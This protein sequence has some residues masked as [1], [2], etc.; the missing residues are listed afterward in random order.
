MTSGKSVKPVPSATSRSSAP[1]GADA[2]STSPVPTV[3]S[4]T[5]SSCAACVAAAAAAAAASSASISSCSFRILLASRAQRCAMVLPFLCAANWAANA[6]G[7]VL[8]TL[9]AGHATLSASKS[10]TPVPYSCNGYLVMISRMVRPILSTTEDSGHCTPCWLLLAPLVILIFA[11]R[12]GSPSTS[13]KMANIF[14]PD[15]H[16]L[17]SSTDL[18]LASSRCC[19][20]DAISSWLVSDAGG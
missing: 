6:C 17:G 5:L 11:L 4:T 12:R 16:P 13:R 15:C 19:A 2:S 20:S 10:L 7:K 3:S 1:N 9:T 14:R 18:P 8:S